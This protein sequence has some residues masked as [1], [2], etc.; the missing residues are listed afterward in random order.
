MPVGLTD[1]P[2]GKAIKAALIGRGWTVSAE[3][4]DGID[5]TPAGNDYTAKIYVGYD[6]RQVKIAYVGSTN[7][8][9]EVKRDGTRLIHA[10][11]MGLDEVSFRRHRP[12]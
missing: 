8:K 5:S 12:Q 4:A 9:Y 3:Q 11:Y 1:V 7:L 6:T 10:N 2:V